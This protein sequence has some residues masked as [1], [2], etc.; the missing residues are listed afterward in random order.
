MSIP[1][2]SRVFQTIA[3][4]LDPNDLI[5]KTLELVE[6]TLAPIARIPYEIFWGL[7]KNWW[8]Q[9]ID[10][11]HHKYGPYVYDKGLHDFTKERGYLLS[12]YAACKMASSPEHLMNDPNVEF[13]KALHSKAC[14]HF[15]GKVVKAGSDKVGVFFAN[16]GDKCCNSSKT[17][18]FCSTPEENDALFQVFSHYDA[19]DDFPFFPKDEPPTLEEL[20]LLYFPYF[21]KLNPSVYDE[22][23]PVE[24]F[25]EDYYEA[26][27]WLKEF[28]D[29]AE[30][31][32]VQMNAYIAETSALLGLSHPMVILES[33]PEGFSTAYASPNVIAFY[34]CKDEELEP[35]VK[36]LFDAY[37]E[38]MAIA[39]ISE[40]KLYLIAD[41]FQAL[42]WIHPFADG[43]GRT[44]L[45][46]LNKELCRHGFTPAILDNP[47]VSTFCS[48]DDW[49]N[50]LKVGMEKWQAE[51][52][53]LKAA[54]PM[55]KV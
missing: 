2:I 24:D 6:S 42:E 38:S 19:Y 31:K 47:Y 35:L 18:L 43:Q 34:L 12:S 15:D 46:L 48:L 27:A 1:P 50:Y 41:L 40:E 28:Q 51:E 49:V 20:T 21:K 32:R 5:Q 7:G 30:E 11:R 39:E 22:D 29:Q 53:R 14:C 52:R 3:E 55:T 33:V 9:H 25:I 37:N 54:F 13:Y 16:L 23:V 8:K 10:G 45:I 36:K 17:Y 4:Y 26:Q 44:D